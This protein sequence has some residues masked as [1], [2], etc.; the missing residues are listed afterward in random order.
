VKA[1]LS[2]EGLSFFE[3]KDLVVR[4]SIRVIEE[5]GFKFNT[6]DSLEFSK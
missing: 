1:S 3:L 4:D 5:R 2:E 6:E